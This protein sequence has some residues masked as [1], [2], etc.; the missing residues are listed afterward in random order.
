MRKAF[1]WTYDQLARGSSLA[2]IARAKKTPSLSKA[3]KAALKHHRELVA[4]DRSAF[5]GKSTLIGVDEVGRGP[6]AGPLVACCVQLPYPAGMALPFLRDSKKLKASE[7]EFLVDRIKMVAV[8]YALGVVEAGEF[9]GDLNLHQLTFLAMT[10]AVEQMDV[11]TEQS[12]L[13]V[14]GKFAL[15]S[16]SGQ[17]EAVVKGDDTSLSIAAASVL[18]K[19]YR[20]QRME[21]L[22]ERYPVYNFSRHVGYGTAAHRQ[23][24]LEHGPCP[25]HRANFL[26]KIL[27]TADT[28][29]V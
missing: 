7:R 8:Q 15:P 16:W 4:F 10:R 6:L 18:A 17:Q 3:V 11:D 9:G 20:D 21:E 25:E 27:D 28:G 19:V 29:S 13:L 12:V 23:A 2:K 22:H 5:S 24:I 1:A 26:T 14:D